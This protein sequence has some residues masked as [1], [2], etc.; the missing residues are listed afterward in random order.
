MLHLSAFVEDG[1]MFRP[2][3][4]WQGPGLVYS[5]SRTQIGGFKIIPI[6]F[7]RA[8]T[9]NIIDSYLLPTEYP[10]NHYSDLIEINPNNLH[11]HI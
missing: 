6:P 10:E 1:G 5:S 4:V 7:F 8:A 2:F 9:E 11:H 3:H